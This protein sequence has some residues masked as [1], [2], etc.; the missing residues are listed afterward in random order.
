M[1]DTFYSL[2]ET[3]N[4]VEITVKKEEYVLI[5]SELNECFS[6]NLLDHV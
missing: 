6:K 5:Q 2:P 3:T 4:V 1:P